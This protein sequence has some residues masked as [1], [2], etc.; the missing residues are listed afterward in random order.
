MSMKYLIYLISLRWGGDCE[1]EKGGAMANKHW[2]QRIL[3]TTR[4]Q[5]LSL[6]RWGPR[7]VSEL[8]A[9]VDLTE[10][11]V[12]LHLSGLERDGLVEQEG[13]RRGAGKPAHVY[14][15][16]REPQ[17]LFPKAYAT[18]LGEVLARIRDE[19]GRSGLGA[20]NSR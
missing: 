15:L 17:N 13:V 9:A 11:A 10:N 1:Q 12:R 18:V 7:T 2:R 6:L 16:S 4:G 19:Q 5:V 8:A 20:A 14:Q 3:A